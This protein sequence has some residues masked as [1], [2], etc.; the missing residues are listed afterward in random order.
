M[1]HLA[2][3]WICLW[4][5]SFLGTQTLGKDAKTQPAAPCVVLILSAPRGWWHADL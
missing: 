4:K 3:G 5:Q 2:L 1:H